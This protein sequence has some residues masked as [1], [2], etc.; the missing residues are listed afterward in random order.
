MF[1]LNDII[2]SLCLKIRLNYHFKIYN[3]HLKEGEGVS[4]PNYIVYSKS[5]VIYHGGDI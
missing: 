2:A 4:S 5:S 1:A 3:Y